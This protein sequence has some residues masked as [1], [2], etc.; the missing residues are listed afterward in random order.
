VTATAVDDRT[1]LPGPAW[2]P[3]SSTSF[4]LADRR[5]VVLAD[6]PCEAGFSGAG[7][8]YARIY[9]HAR[10]FDPRLGVFLSPD[11][12]GVA[13]GMNLYGYGL[14]NPVNGTDRSGLLKDPCVE[15]GDIDPGCRPFVSSPLMGLG[16]GEF[17][18]VITGPSG[19]ILS[20][21]LTAAVAEHELQLIADGHGGAYAYADI[22][23][24]TSVTLDPVNTPSLDDRY[25][26]LET[27][28]V[29]EIK[30]TYPGYQVAENHPAVDEKLKNPFDQAAPIRDAW[31]I[32]PNVDGTF[33]RQRH[34][35][36]SCIQTRRNSPF[37]A[38]WQWDNAVELGLLITGNRDS[39]SDI[40]ANLWGFWGAGVMPARTCED[41]AKCSPFNRPAGQ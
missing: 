17:L 6:D 33:D 14:G 25:T 28:F 41:I 5:R 22:D 12:I 34:T 16:M 23:G 19:G 37:F 39:A 3:A 31:V 15:G 9:L 40:G 27:G 11:P 35:Y 18:S 29:V 26:H 2:P 4:P 10:Y 32:F 1:L 7:P 13:G 21:T 24:T 36:I 30:W 8:E 20:P 38:W